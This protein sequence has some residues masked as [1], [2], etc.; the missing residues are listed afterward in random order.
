MI[1]QIEN[2]YGYSNIDNLIPGVR[3]Q[4]AFPTMEFK[5]SDPFLML[6][7]I[8]PQKVGKDY[9]LNGEGHDHRRARA[10]HARGLGGVSGR[11]GGL[12]GSGGYEGLGVGLSA[13]GIVGA[14]GASSGDPAGGS[15]GVSGL[16]CQ[17]WR[18]P[19]LRA[20]ISAA[21]RLAFR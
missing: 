15:E 20:A 11:D 9:R 8:G 16:K 13:G 6:D 10:T 1:K 4:R 5:A 18:L 12:P 21:L 17:S 14:R 3:G 2:I 7:H 19:A